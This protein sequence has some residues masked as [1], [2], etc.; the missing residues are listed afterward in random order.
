MSMPACLHVKVFAIHESEG[1][2]Y[3]YTH[4]LCTEGNLSGLATSGT[5]R[6]KHN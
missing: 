1:G 2:I 4:M 5:V 3:V 6:I